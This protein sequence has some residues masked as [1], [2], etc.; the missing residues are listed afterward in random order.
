MQVPSSRECWNHER[1]DSTARHAA[2]KDE[3]WRSECNHPRQSAAMVC[4]FSAGAENMPRHLYQRIHDAYVPVVM[5][6]NE[7]EVSI[8]EIAR[9]AQVNNGQGQENNKNENNDGN[10]VNG[11][12]AGGGL[13]NRPIQQQ[14]LALHSSNLQMRRQ[15]DDII[16]LLTE[17]RTQTQRN[18]QTLNTNIRRIA[19]APVRRIGANQGVAESQPGGGA[20]G[21]ANAIGGV[22]TLSPTP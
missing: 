19:M 4:F 13:A 12:Y 21:A 5:T 17:Y 2:R 18:Y 7:A 11:A 22:A 14:L 3:N 9:E 15:L 1:M 6:G 10:A 20:V 8:D 16:E